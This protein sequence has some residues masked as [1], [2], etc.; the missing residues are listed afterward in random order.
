MAKLSL[1]LGKSVE[2]FIEEKMSQE[3]RRKMEELEVARLRAREEEDKETGR[4]GDKERG[5]KKTRRGGDKESGR[6]EEGKKTPRFKT[7]Y[8]IIVRRKTG[9]GKWKMENG[10]RNTEDGK[11]KTGN[12]KWEMENGKRKTEDG[13]PKSVRSEELGVRSKTS[14][15]QETGN[16]KPGSVNRKPEDVSRKKKIKRGESI[17]RWDW[18]CRKIIEWGILGLIV[19]T[20]LA[21]GSVYE[22]TILVIQLA[23]LVMMGA[24]ILMKKKPRMNEGLSFSLRW[25]RYL[26]FGFIIFLFIQAVPW[27]K[28]LVKILSPNTYVFQELFSADF[29]RVKFMSFSL[30]PE[31]TIRE[32]LELLAYFFLGFL[33]VK[34][35][36]KRK[37][38]MRIFYVLVGVGVFQAVYGFIQ[39]YSK[40]P[41]VLFY[42]KIHGLDSLSGT[43][44]N[45]NHLSGYLEMVIPLTIGLILAHIDV[46][47]L[48]GLKWR[49]K[50]LRF[51]EKGFYRNVLL[52]FGVI[53]MAMAI[54]F[55]K[56]RSGVFLLVFA[57]ILFF[58][59][60]GLYSGRVTHRQKWTMGFLK[61]TFLAIM[62]ISLYVGINATIERFALDNLL[63]QNRPL[64]WSNTTRITNDFPFL[65]SGLG[66]FASIYPAYEELRT[67]AHLS[68]AHND[69]LEYLAE[70]GVLGMILLCGVILFLLVRSFLVWRE[71]RHPEVKGLALGGMIA[72]VLM[73]IHSIGDFNLHIPA[74]M[75][76]FSV[77]LSLTFVLVFYRMRGN[78]Q[79]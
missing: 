31:Q 48:A 71:R 55:S 3:K 38:I 73:L 63:Y 8:K 30:M 68:H 34:T 29:S 56:S 40:N 13:R 28:F 62:F 39:L 64:Y 5:R 50:L 54:L 9:N 33:I 16:G 4:V 58:G 10:E 65:G 23:V 60:A 27:P 18:G 70:L 14:S 69:Y 59:L 17:T 52:T 12:G 61:G 1:G 35:V 21:A 42:K 45:R 74:N 36:T 75:L 32:G 67:A 57:F 26:F 43:F 15:K 22:W 44:V 11:R 51:S 46:F 79:P 2:E 7:K 25:P 20:P 76:L 37:Q 78:R 41:M 72:V 47:S 19:W 66:T 77:V 49:E 24:Y 53:V 6:K